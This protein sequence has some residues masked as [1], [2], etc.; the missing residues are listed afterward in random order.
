MKIDTL[1]SGLIVPVASPEKT[2]E[3]PRHYG[4]LEF[5]KTEDREAIKAAMVELWKAMRLREG[6]YQFEQASTDRLWEDRHRL[7]RFIG[8]NLLGDECPDLEVLC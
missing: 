5:R 8:E 7:W 2:P 1:P 6:S 3:P 4:S